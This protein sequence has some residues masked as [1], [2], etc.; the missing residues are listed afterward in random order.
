MVKAGRIGAKPTHQRAASVGIHQRKVGMRPELFNSLQSVGQICHGLN[1]KPLVQNQSVSLGFVVKPLNKIVANLSGNIPVHRH[2]TIQCRNLV[3]HARSSFVMTLG[4]FRGRSLFFGS[5]LDG[6]EILEADIPQSSGTN[7]NGIDLKFS[8]AHAFRK[9]IVSF[10]EFFRKFIGQGLLQSTT[11][12]MNRNRVNGSR[13]DQFDQ[14]SLRRKR[15]SVGQNRIILRIVIQQSSLKGLLDVLPRY[16]LLQGTSV[17]DL[18]DETLH[19][20]LAGFPLVEAVRI[21]RCQKGQILLVFVS[22]HRI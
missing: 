22:V 11:G 1:R 4:Q 16:R 18:K 5:L 6:T 14:S 7:R 21:R 19:Q 20:R 2:Q 12:R 15:Q 17:H 3:C 9:S 8:P 10:L 13:L